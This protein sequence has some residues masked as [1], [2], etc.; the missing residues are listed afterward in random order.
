MLIPRQLAQQCLPYLPCDL[1]LPLPLHRDGIVHVNAQLALPALDGEEPHSG[2]DGV[3]VCEA[4]R[5]DGDAG[6]DGHGERPALE[7]HEAAIGT[8]GAL[9][10]CHD[11]HPI[12]EVAHGLLERAELGSFCVAVDED[13][14]S[15]H[16]L[17]SHP[18]KLVEA[19]LGDELEHRIQNAAQNRNV[20]E[21]GVVRHEEACPPSIAIAT[22]LQSGN[23]PR[24]LGVAAR[25]G[26]VR[27][28]PDL[29]RVVELGAI[30][31]EPFHVGS[32][33]VQRLQR[34]HPHGHS[35]EDDDEV[36]QARGVQ[37][38]GLAVL[39]EREAGTHLVDREDVG[40]RR[41][42]VGR[43]DDGGG[44]GGSV[45]VVVMRCMR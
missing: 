15:P 21:R 26:Q 42:V 30:L 2:H 17:P 4:Q 8:P 7:G 24:D 22:F 19:V 44:D 31:V 10:K 39:L 41:R 32:E 45:A 40:R 1:L 14:F 38:L 36:E 34:G 43:D 23:V 3:G 27:P 37:N 25:H 5:N 20:Q 29:A 6:L 35:E 28:A 12:L 13:M 11:G 9:G 33:P 18:R 16:Q